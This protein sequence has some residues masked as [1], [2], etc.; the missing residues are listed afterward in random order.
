MISDER[1][2]LD[3]RV[4]DMAVN[5]IIDVE[6]ITTD[7]YRFSIS[8]R[9]VKGQSLIKENFLVGFVYGRQVRLDNNR[10]QSLRELLFERTLVTSAVLFNVTRIGR[11]RLEFLVYLSR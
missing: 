8:T 7:F 5:F 1:A 4:N 10:K 11:G 2:S 3:F 9:L 6:T